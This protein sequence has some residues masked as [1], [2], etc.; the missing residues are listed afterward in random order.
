MIRPQ[1]EGFVRLLTCSCSAESITYSETFTY[2]LV[3]RHHAD[4]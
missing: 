4:I 2:L 3:Y 1:T